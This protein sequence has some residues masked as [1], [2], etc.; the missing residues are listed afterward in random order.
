MMAT[1]LFRNGDTWY[2]V[3]DGKPVKADD[4]T[5]RMEELKKGRYET[6]Q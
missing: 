3:I 2:R 4:I 6:T 1:R 5:K